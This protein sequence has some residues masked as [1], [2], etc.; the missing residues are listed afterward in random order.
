M[1]ADG[2]CAESPPK[3]LRSEEGESASPMGAD[4]ACAK[5]PAE[6]IRPDDG[7]SA[8]NMDADSACTGSLAKKFVSDDGECAWPLAASNRHLDNHPPNWR[9]KR[10][11]ADRGQKRKPRL[12]PMIPQLRTGSL[13]LSV[14]RAAAPAKVFS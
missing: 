7:N 2:A 9:H 12:A 5:N 8:S 10:Y 3:K 1:D 13:D 6:K 14:A 4:G 11:R